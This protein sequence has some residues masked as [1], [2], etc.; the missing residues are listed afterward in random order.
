MLVAIHTH[1]KLPY[2]LENPKIIAIIEII[3]IIS[4]AVQVLRSWD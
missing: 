3:A 2:M 4:K 1:S